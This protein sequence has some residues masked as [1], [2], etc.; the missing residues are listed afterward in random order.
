MM[1]SELDYSFVS[2][3]RQTPVPETGSPPNLHITGWL[4]DIE[5]SA[6]PLNPSNQ[7]QQEIPKSK[8]INRKFLLYTDPRRKLK[9][10]KLELIDIGPKAPLEPLPSLGYDVSIKASQKKPSSAKV[11]NEDNPNLQIEIASSVY[12]SQDSGSRLE[13]ASKASQSI[14]PHFWIPGNGPLT[15]Q[16]LRE[17]LFVHR[18]KSH[19]KNSG[20][21]EIICSGQ[22]ERGRD[23]VSRELQM[24]KTD[25]DSSS[26]RLLSLASQQRNDL[27]NAASEPESSFERPA[28][29][30][31]SPR[32]LEPFAVPVVDQIFIGAN[33]GKTEEVTSVD[34]LNSLPLDPQISTQTRSVPGGGDLSPQLVFDSAVT[35]GPDLKNDPDEETVASGPLLRLFPLQPIRLAIGSLLSAI[36]NLL[37]RALDEYFPDETIPGDHIRIH[38]TCVGRHR[39]VLNF[40]IPDTIRRSVAGKCLMILLKHSPELLDVLNHTSTDLGNTSRR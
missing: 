34:T 1:D 25:T 16:S 4:Q 8:G 2:P 13:A 24:L 22:R 32:L 10:N 39:S 9:K 15:L 37:R 27:L 35:D 29:N 11:Q 40:K 38:W 21:W 23:E 31:V 14:S 28:G 19:L 36:L 12:C 33:D 30:L 5:S 7:E 3:D 18:I 6:E 17:A 20:Q 26:A